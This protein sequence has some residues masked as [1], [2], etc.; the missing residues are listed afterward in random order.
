MY[1]D[2]KY[3]GKACPYCRFPIKKE[4][5]NVLCSECLIAHHLECWHKNK[6]CTTYDCKGKLCSTIDFG[7]SNKQPDTGKALLPLYKKACLAVLVT[8]ILIGLSL[9]YMNLLR[10]VAV[11]E[12]E[13]EVLNK[14]L[15]DLKSDISLLNDETVELENHL[16]SVSS[17]D[18]TADIFELRGLVEVRHVD[19]NI[20]VNLYYATEENITGEVLYPVEVCLLQRGTAEKLAAANAEFMR[21]G[22]RLKIWDGYRPLNVQEALWEKKPDPRYVA[23]PAVGSNHNRGAAVDVTLVDEDG[24]KLEM[25]TGFDDFE[26]EASRD[27]EGMSKEARENMDYLT[28]VMIRNGFTPIQSEWW[29][30]NDANVYE[31]DFIDLTLEEFLEQYFL[32]NIN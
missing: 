19:S 11:K 4:T 3:L 1:L 16:T 25:P 23:D 15:N 21:D 6:G 31:Y 30:F 12:A 26:E 18:V 8:A 24:N 29:H 14:N 7:E 27:Y 20:L 28:E 9:G 17:E 13:I 22:Y 10:Q 2:N 5:D 32:Y